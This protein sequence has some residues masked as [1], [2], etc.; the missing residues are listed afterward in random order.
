[1]ARP[2]APSSFPSAAR[3][4]SL[5]PGAAA[6]ALAV[7]LVQAALPAA[8]ASTTNPAALP[9]LSAGLSLLERQYLFGDE[10]VLGRLLR[11]AAKAF[12]R[13]I[14]DVT[15][16]E[17]AEGEW[18]YT[19][20]DCELRFA[21]PTGAG[22]QALEAPLS[23]L[24][25]FLARCSRHLPPRMPEMDAY[26]LGGVLSGLDPYSAVFDEKRQAEHNIQFQGKLA[27]IGARV[28]IRKDLSLIHI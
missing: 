24:G 28:G 16:V 9:A 23:D 21:V 7:L 3:R 8:S 18:L 20:P 17:L 11:E 2:T 22:L 26:L 1:M 6:C 25:R 15:A 27:G 13:D 10:L 19:T 5:R 14:P 4:R 12:T